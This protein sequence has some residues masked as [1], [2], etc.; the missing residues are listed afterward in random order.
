MNNQ[1]R[2][3]RPGVILSLILAFAI[4]PVPSRARQSTESL[5][6]KCLFQRQRGTEALQPFHQGRLGTH[7]EKAS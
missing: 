3:L 4:S 7:L 5:P 2:R 1:Q 6:E